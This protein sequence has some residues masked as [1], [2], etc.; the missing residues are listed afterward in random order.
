M[1]FVADKQSLKSAQDTRKGK[2]RKAVPRR[3][4]APFSFFE[5]ADSGSHAA[6]ISL[7]NSKQLALRMQSQRKPFTHAYHF[8]NAPLHREQVM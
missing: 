7:D 8:Q 5:K 6:L 2:E 4:N 1:L 3:A